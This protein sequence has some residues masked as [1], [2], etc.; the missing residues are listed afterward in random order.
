M[1]YLVLLLALLSPGVFAWEKVADSTYSSYGTKISVDRMDALPF[2]EL[3]YNSTA[4]DFKLYFISRDGE[5]T[6]ANYGM[7]NMRSCG[8]T[9][10]GAI[11]KESIHANSGPDLH[12]VFID[13]K[14]PMFLRVWN[15]YNGHTTYKFENLGP[16]EESKNE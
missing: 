3:I 8:T 11:V 10:T 15:M 4:D 14:R 7:F 5:R 13:C 1:K 2:A 16:L 9:T 12:R 6:T